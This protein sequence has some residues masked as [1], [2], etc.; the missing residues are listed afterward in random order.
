LGSL[1]QS[2]GIIG[3][4]C[5]DTVID[6]ISYVKAAK[7]GHARTLDG[8]LNPEATVNDDEAKWCDAPALFSGTNYGSPG[9]INL[10]CSGM[11]TVEGTCLDTDGTTR[12]VVLPA[13]GQLV[14]SEMMANPKAVLDSAGEWLEVRANAEVDLNGL[15]LYSG[16]SKATVSSANCL[17]LGNSSY[18]VFA[19]NA[20]A[21]VNGGI[22]GVMGTFSFQLGNSAVTTLSVNLP[23]AGVIDTV[24]FAAALDGVAWQVDPT[25][26]TAIDNDDPLSLCRATA[27]YGAGDL[28]TPGASNSTCPTPIDMNSCIDSSTGMPRPIARPVVGDLVITEVMAR[29]AKVG[30]SDGEWFEVLAT[31]NIDFNGLTLNYDTSGTT[32]L[33]SQTC[34]SATAGTY[35]LFARK[36]DA[37][38]NGGLPAVMATHSFGLGDMGSHTLSIKNGMTEL[39]AITYSNA[40]S[41][42][43]WQVDPT[44]LTT[45]DND[46]PMNQ[47]RATMM[48]GAGDLGTPGIANSTCPTP[49]DMNNCVDSLTGTPRPIVRPAVGD[50]VITEFMAHPAQV[51]ASDGEWFEV[52]AK[53]NVDFNGLTLA[54]D[55]SGMSTVAS[56]TCLSAATGTYAVFARK[57]DSLVNGG[58][59]SVLATFNFGLTDTGMHTLAL[60]NGTTEVDAITY[61]ATS[62]GTSTQLSNAKLDAVQN[63]LPASFCLT[64]SATYGM[65]PDGGMGDKGSPGAANELCP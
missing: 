21:G 55:S 65:S 52:L 54:F 56:Q 18:A 19:K 37:L 43:A 40:L 20:D 58:I 5:R 22:S 48:Y 41:G 42:V 38:V 45:T 36:A 7:A 17:R 26:L 47:C 33:T 60:K 50:L 59:P 51:G 14:I 53:A 28:G 39:D 11:M 25:K 61:T 32:T 34:L 10:S 15:L 13:A 44:K 49:I 30:A 9:Q 64:I 63:D 57:S 6:E 35:V 12:A 24:T 31:S 8:T 16:T 27:M 29:P 46:D 62:T 2:G 4:R 1:P 23:D 3:L